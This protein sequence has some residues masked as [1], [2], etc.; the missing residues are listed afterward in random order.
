MAPERPP[1]KR[2][3]RETSGRRPHEAFALA[4]IPCPIAVTPTGWAGL[5]AI[6]V[7]PKGPHGRQGA[8]ASF[9]RRLHFPCC[10]ECAARSFEAA[11]QD[12]EAA[13]MAAD[14]SEA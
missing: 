2:R 6:S 9:A 8:R 10:R 11:R 7:H 3:Q 5:E 14:T 1:S 12:F 13:M 4:G